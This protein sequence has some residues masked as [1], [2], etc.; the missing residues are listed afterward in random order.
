MAHKK[1]FDKYG[2][3]KRVVIQEQVFGEPI[4]AS[5]GEGKALW[6]GGWWHGA[7]S[8]AG[9][10]FAA[11]LIAGKQTSYDDFAKVR[12]PV[13]NLPL[14]DFTSARWCYWMQNTEA[15]G[16]SLS[17]HVHDPLDFDKEAEISQIPD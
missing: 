2:R 16:V 17:I 8:R 10:G 12:I 6:E 4:L 9:S 14:I 11:R 15:Y 7:S 13:D 3:P 1:L 5:G